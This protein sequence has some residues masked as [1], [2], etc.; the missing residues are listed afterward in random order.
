MGISHSCVFRRFPWTSQCSQQFLRNPGI[1]WKRCCCR[2][3]LHS[4]AGRQ[5]WRMRRFPAYQDDPIVFC[6]LQASGH[7]FCW[8]LTET[9]L[10]TFYGVPWSQK[11]SIESIRPISLCHLFHRKRM[12]EEWEVPVIWLNDAIILEIMMMDQSE[13]TESTRLREGPGSMSYHVLAGY[14]GC[15]L[16]HICVYISWEM[17]PLYNLYSTCG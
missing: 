5:W 16:L 14:R 9:G 4:T 15:E 2:R 8:N 6:Q 12:L 3:H 1:P 10:H 7:C 13:F 17:G 11:V